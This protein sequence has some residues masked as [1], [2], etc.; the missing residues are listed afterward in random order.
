[1]V[2]DV[3]LKGG[4]ILDSTQAMDMIGEI[5]LRSGKIAAIGTSIPDSSNS[6]V[7]DVSGKIVCAGLIDF[8]AHVY[9]GGT[10]LG[11]NPD[12]YGPPSGT[13]TYV[14]AGSAGPGNFQGLLHHVMNTS[15]INIFP[16]LN[17]S[18]AGI[19]YYSDFIKI[20][21]LENLNAAA[22]PAVCKVVDEYRDVIKGLKVRVGKKTSA[23]HGMTPLNLARLAA[24][25]CKKPLMIHFDD[26]P[27]TA[28][29]VLDFLQDGDILC[30]VFH[31][32]VN[33]VK[34]DL[35]K[36]QQA[37]QRGAYFDL[38][39]GMGSFT[40]N[41]A[42]TCIEAGFW[43]DTIST[44]LHI[45]SMRNVGDLPEL[46]SKMVAL[47]MPLNNVVDCVTCKPAGILNEQRIGNLKPGSVADIAVLEAIEGD[48]T[49][50]DCVGDVLKSTMK[51]SCRLTIRKGGIVFNQLKTVSA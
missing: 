46:M 45:Q 31:G 49:F 42:R 20:G 47:G 1:M 28:G 3:V 4:R 25:A 11:I 34:H 16:Y 15:T 7:I 6:P 17:I 2:Y 12:V 50:T 51:L 48:Y 14:D 36:L 41:V 29:E 40:F 38:G 39:H 33:H 23:Y 5:G 10:S 18:F 43:P 26:A 37:R 21:E 27:P 44:D 19:P 8:H 24:M 32:G 30:H 22:I 13:T 35:V 9:W